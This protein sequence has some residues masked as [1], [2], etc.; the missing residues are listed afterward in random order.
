MPQ[1]K[2]LL[3]GVVMKKIFMSAA[4][5]LPFMAFSA[6]ANADVVY[7]SAT[8]DV[9][10]SMTADYSATATPKTKTLSASKTSTHVNNVINKGLSSSD[11]ASANSTHGTSGAAN[12]SGTATS[13]LALTSAADGVFTI[14]GNS[15]ASTTNAASSTANASS[16]NYGSGSYEFTVTAPTTVTLTATDTQTCAT[17][18][19]EVVTLDGKTF[20]IAANTTET[21]TVWLGNTGTYTLDVYDSAATTS[22]PDYAYINGSGTHSSAGSFDSTLSFSM[23]SGV[24]EVSSWAMMLA[25]FG[26]LGFVGFRRRKSDRLAV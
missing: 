5:A 4:V 11:N 18:G 23:V 13:S 1:R 22:G 15:T 3:I 25:G 21:F 7:L 24:P 8:V 10:G 2:G 17:C 9:G 26:A 12:A 19:Y 16:Y 20:D 6:A 14:T